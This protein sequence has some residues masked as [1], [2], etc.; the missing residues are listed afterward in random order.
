MRERMRQRHNP[1]PE[2]V[3]MAV[4]RIARTPK[5]AGK[6]Y[7]IAKSIGLPGVRELVREACGFGAE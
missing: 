2:S 4:E 3:A 5:H 1:T 6:A 7:R